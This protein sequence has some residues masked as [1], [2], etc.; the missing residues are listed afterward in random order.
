VDPKESIA[1]RKAST[2]MVAREKEEII[3]EEF[4]MTFRELE[5]YIFNK[6]FKDPTI[7]DEFREWFRPIL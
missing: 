7:P 1:Y 2:I 3:E 4:S 5:E 6:Y